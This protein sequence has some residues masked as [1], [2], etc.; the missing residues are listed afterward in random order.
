MSTLFDITKLVFFQFNLDKDRSDG[1]YTFIGKKGAGKSWPQALKKVREV[2][3]GKLPSTSHTPN[4]YPGAYKKLSIKLPNNDKK[5]LLIFS[6]NAD[7]RFKKTVRPIVLPNGN[8]NDA[9]G[10]S[11]ILAP[12]D[13]NGTMKIIDPESGSTNF[14]D[15]AWAAITFD[16]SRVRQADKYI[17]AFMI[18]YL[19]EGIAPPEDAWPG[20]PHNTAT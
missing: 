15:N 10:D 20:P 8:P 2:F 18:D 12:D 19:D 4:G 6:I 17:F 1:H 16:E 5:N 9:F 13:A 14:P 7:A 3:D 11:F